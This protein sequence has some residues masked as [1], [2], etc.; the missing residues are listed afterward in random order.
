MSDCCYNCFPLGQTLIKITAVLPW[1]KACSWKFWV[2]FDNNPFNPEIYGPFSS[3]V[4]YEVIKNNISLVL[5]S[6][7][8]TQYCGAVILLGTMC[9]YFNHTFSKRNISNL[10]P[11][12]GCSKMSYNKA[13]C[14]EKTIHQLFSLN[15]HI[16]NYRVP[17]LAITLKTVTAEQ[18]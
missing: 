16:S 11:Q 7:L 12:P 4:K 13:F 6:T 15:N 1:G 10:T 2:Q 8:L 5:D 9:L 14:L 3:P 17:C 18:L